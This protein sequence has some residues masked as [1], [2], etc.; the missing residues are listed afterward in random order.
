MP[1]WLQFLIF[2]S[3][4]L[5]ILGGAHFY[6]WHR[7]ARDTG[8]T[9]RWRH[10][11]RVVFVL[12]VL[13][14]PLEHLVTRAV[15]GKGSVVFAYFAYG[16]MG[17]CFYAFVLLLLV[18]LVL[19]VLWR[20]RRAA[21]R[22]A[23]PEDPERRRALRRLLNGGA[24]V[25][26][27]G[28]LVYGGFVAFADPE[29]TDL[30]VRLPRLPRALSG[31]TIAHLTDVHVGPIVDERF[32]RRMVV[33]TNRLQPDVVVITG[34]LFDRSV[35][36]L[37]GILP[38][39]RALRSRYGTFFVTGN[40]EFYV[41][42]EPLCA[43]LRGIGVTVL[44]N[45]RVPLGDGAASLDLLGV[46]DWS[47]GTRRRQP[48]RQPGPGRND[49]DPAL[50]GRDPERAAVLLAHQPRDFAR[51]AAAGVGLQL[52]G[53]T[54][55]GQMFPIIGIS[56]LAYRWAAGHYRLGDAHI[57]VS[58]GIGFWGPPFRVLAPPEIAKITLV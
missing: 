3:V 55:G 51:A 24:A 10:V 35:E 30:P 31:L 33:A 13:A 11:L 44:R 14:F 46:D 28:V 57:Y 9:S 15:G 23:P 34:D 36:D 7:L 53:H 22:E 19:L 56:K 45:Q 18:D 43:A 4:A 41:G 8:L 2:L 47:A 52:S 39:L 37:G 38:E 29:V 42:V 54:H 58:R 20:H 26:S 12:G 1:L 50:A 21:R 48:G 32:V 17:F 49:L 5:A 16:W 27:G 40:H 6:L 25:A